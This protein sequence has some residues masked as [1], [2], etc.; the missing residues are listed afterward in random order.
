MAIIISTVEQFC[1]LFL[2]VIYELF[3][4]NEWEKEPLG[5]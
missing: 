2:A 5:D 1:N 3:L 4:P